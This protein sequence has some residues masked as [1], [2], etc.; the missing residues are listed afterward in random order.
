MLNDHSNIMRFI[1][2]SKVARELL[3]K[4]VDEEQINKIILEEGDREILDNPQ[5]ISEVDSEF[6][7]L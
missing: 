3:E 7:E 1:K 5:V 6:R 4:V 2:G